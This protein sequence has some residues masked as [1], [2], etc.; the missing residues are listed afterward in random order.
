MP[1]RKAGPAASPASPPSVKLTSIM[2]HRILPAFIVENAAKKVRFEVERLTEDDIDTDVEAFYETDPESGELEN[3]ELKE[4]IT[5][6]LINAKEETLMTMFRSKEYLVE[7]IE[8]RNLQNR[9]DS[10]EILEEGEI[11]DYG[12]DDDNCPYE[13]DMNCSN[14]TLEVS[15]D[16]FF[17]FIWN[18]VEERIVYG[19]I[20]PGPDEV[21]RERAQYFLRSDPVVLL[22]VLEIALERA[23]E[24][25]A[26]MEAAQ[27]AEA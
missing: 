3:L 12:S 17:K 20:G 21:T 15:I 18:N 25:L 9:L 10:G 8:Q 7:E 11:R 2:K 23:S 26:A 4:V 5:D 16:D 27:E 14:A 6:E 19:F 13:F 22:E 24:K 1:P